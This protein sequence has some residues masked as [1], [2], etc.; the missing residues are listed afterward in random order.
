MHAL[1]FEKTHQDTKAFVAPSIIT[2]A[3]S[4]VVLL[5]VVASTVLKHLS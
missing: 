2:L 5:A 3:L 4:P 1:F